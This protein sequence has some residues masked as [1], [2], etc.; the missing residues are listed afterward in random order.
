MNGYINL[1]VFI[2]TTILYFVSIKP[3]VK[4]DTLETPQSSKGLAIYALIILLTQFGLNVSAI[5]E[6]CG[7]SASQ[8]IGVAALFTF[9][10]W[11][12]IFGIVLVV[13][14][15]FPGFKTAFSDVIGYFYI[16]DKA[17]ILFSEML[18]IKGDVANKIETLPTSEKSAASSTADA[19][20]KLCGNMGILINQIVPSNFK[21]FWQLLGPLMKTDSML[22]AQPLY[23]NFIKTEREKEQ[24]EA[25]EEGM[26]TIESVT[27]QTGGQSN[28]PASDYYR[29]E[30]LKLVVSRDNVGE[31][32]WYL[33]TG[34]LV[35]SIVQY[36]ILSRGCLSD[37][38]TMEK[39]YQK[40]LQNEDDLKAQED[41]AGQNTIYTVTA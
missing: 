4:Y 41:A 10:P 39:N 25:K 21:D 27:P 18:A 36:Y 1:I 14:I 12:L 13:L 7:G 15:V 3:E 32:M 5:I 40:F 22:E 26:K 11:T 31:F 2:L 17:H 9:L 20:I 29:D 16:S 37:S 30:L 33:Y 34:I 28:K 35:I 19:L 23:Q 24:E 8:N 6:K 38:A